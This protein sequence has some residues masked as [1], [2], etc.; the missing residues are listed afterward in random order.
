[1]VLRS[2][3][4]ELAAAIAPGPAGEAAPYPP[5]SAPSGAHSAPAT[6]EQQRLWLLQQ[7]DPESR[8]YSVPLAF[9]LDGAP[10]LGALREALRRS[11]ARHPA[12]RTGFRATPEG[13]YQ[14]VAEA[15][16]PWGSAD[17]GARSGPG[18]PL[19]PGASA[20]RVVSSAPGIPADLRTPSGPGLRAAPDAPAD[21]G[22]S[23]DA[24]A[25]LDPHMPGD[26][27]VSGNGQA[28]PDHG[29]SVGSH[30]SMDT[31]ALA[32]P[33]ASAGA[34]TG[35]SGPDKDG[36]RGPAQRFFAEPFDLA[37][38]RML[39]ARWLPDSNVLLLHLHHIAV[40]GW[41][42]NVL[43]RELSADYAAVLA[44]A[45]AEERDAPRDNASVPTPLDFAAWQAE[46][47]TRQPYRDQRAALRAHYETVEDVAAPLR[48]IRDGGRPA[49]RL[50]HTTLDLVRRSSLDRLGAELGLTRFQLLLG[51]FAWS[52]YG[53]TGRAHPLIASPV[54][55]RPVREFEAGVGMFANTVLLPLTLAPH[56]GLRAQLLRQGAAAQAVLDRQDVLL[57]D[58][59]ADHPFRAEGPPF[60]FMFVLENTEF[61]ALT[62]PG[63][64]IR[65][66]WPR[67][68]EAKCPLTLSVVEREAGFD[69]LW[70]YADDHFDSAE[71]ES[72]ARLFGDGLDRLDEGGTGTLGALVAPYRRGLTDLGKGPSAPLAFTTVAEGFARQVRRTPAAPAVTTGGRTLSY[73]ELDAQASALATEIRDRYALSPDDTGPRCV[74]LHLGP[75]AEHVVALLALA[76]LNV[77]IVPLD[78]AYPPALLRQILDQVDPLCVLLP[79]GGEAQLDAVAPAGL[80]HHPV[81]LAAS[82]A[83]ASP[84]TPHDGQRPLYT[85]FTSG[86]TGTPKGVQVPDRTLCNL[87]Q[88]QSDSGGP[89]APAVTQQFSMLSFDVSFQEIFTTL[90]GGGHLH[91]VRP[92]WRHD[93]PA[94]LDQLESMRRRAR[95]H[96]VRGPPAPRRTRRPPRPLP[97]PAA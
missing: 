52:L 38:P 75:S 62:L 45:D 31:G 76:R 14:E 66:V 71:V 83:P 36:W 28:T 91:L 4:A 23:V 84:W 43:F 73:A 27:R 13:L 65:P 79:P 92:E 77:T 25:G 6:S 34:D 70:E 2:T 68:V 86:S 11:V 63:R 26:P 3:F 46:W 67:P 17:P 48:P 93:V 24:R 32:D 35:V 90:C 50:L 51:V 94:L 96:A 72:V 37:E 88:W 30:V 16:D 8:A 41:S 54:A 89:G 22:V 19:G 58:A 80:A 44:G 81:T 20:G 82:P 9:Q 78:P 64:E 40:D 21:P 87:L 61:G 97:L 55:N 59:L 53:V 29:A 10:D 49:G 39:R 69:C 42:L 18:A 33:G 74:A 12:L 1:M 5:V 57:A 56:D 47:F 7:R 15:Y 60:D 85:L 95:L